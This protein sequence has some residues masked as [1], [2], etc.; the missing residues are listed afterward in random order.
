MTDP[1]LDRLAR[2]LVHYS[3]CVQP[4]DAVA[5]VGPPLAEPLLLPLYRE[6]LLAGGHP[7][8]QMEPETCAELLL[9]HG[10]ADQLSHLNPLEARLIE[11]VNVSIHLLAPQNTRCLT[12]V[13]PARQ[14]L[15]GAARAQ[16]MDAFLHRA[17]TRSLRWVVAQVPCQAAAQDAEMSLAEY[18]DFVFAACR[19]DLADP[20]AA[21]YG[22]SESQ[23]KLIDHLQGVSELRFRTSGGTDLRL[24]VAGRTWL[25]SDGRENMPDGEVFTGPVED[26]TEGV[27]CISCPAIH[28]GREVESVR[29]EFR[30]GRVVAASAAKGEEYLVGVL[31]QDAGARVLGEVALGCNYAVTRPTRN[32]LFDEKI[33]GTFHVALGASYPASGG[34]NVSSLHWD[35]ICD[36]R[37]GGAIEA[38][39]SIISRDGRFVDTAWPRA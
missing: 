37:Q 20:I 10:N 21:W 32:A 8:V 2:V 13:E 14:A 29:L 28:K 24:S 3:A 27:I 30:A 18:E 15:I 36:L 17:A 31:D 39:G 35:L 11:S 26:S 16:L 19:V 12:Q 23:Q 34:R 33:G 1:R 7:C 5:L 38:D 25:N 22:L 9:K 6:I 4:G